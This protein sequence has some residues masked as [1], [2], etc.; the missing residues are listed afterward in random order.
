MYKTLSNLMKLFQSAAERA[1]FNQACGLNHSTWGGGSGKSVCIATEQHDL[2]TLL[3]HV[4]GTGLS[5]ETTEEAGMGLQ[6]SESK[7]SSL[8][9]VPPLPLH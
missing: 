1:T 9:T 6:R 7:G 2:S 4:S 5:A 8:N 3:L